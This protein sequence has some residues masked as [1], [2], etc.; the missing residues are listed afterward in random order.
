MVRQKETQLKLIENKD[1]RRVTFFKRKKGLLLKGME[2][3]NMCG[4]KALIF[5]RD[6]KRN[7]IT[8]YSSHKEFTA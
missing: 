7:K 4:K 8:K 5:I 2:L 6:P 1:R 3:T